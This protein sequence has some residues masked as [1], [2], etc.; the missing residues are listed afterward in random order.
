VTVNQSEKGIIRL[1][2][3]LRLY[4]KGDDMDERWMSPWFP[5]DGL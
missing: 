1:S 4:E 3:D 2:T 5:G